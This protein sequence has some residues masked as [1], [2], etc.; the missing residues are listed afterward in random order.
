MQLCILFI[1]HESTSEKF[2]IFTP[3][4]FD[5]WVRSAEKNSTFERI[6]MS[7][8]VS[9]R[10]QLLNCAALGGTIAISLPH[11]MASQRLAE[12][13]SPTQDTPT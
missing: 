13:V 3:S 2:P 8:N 9:A 6:L 11:L 7:A 1:E 12:I 5:L 10:R 4:V